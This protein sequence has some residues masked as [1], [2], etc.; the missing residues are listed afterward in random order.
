MTRLALKVAYSV[1]EAADLCGVD[2]RTMLR[3]VRMG[4]LRAERIGRVFRIPNSSLRE[5]P[6]LWDSILFRKGVTD[7]K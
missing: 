1:P 6:D 5:H 2:R 4:R 7:D 3:W